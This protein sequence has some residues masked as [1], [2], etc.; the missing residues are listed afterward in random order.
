MLNIISIDFLGVSVTRKIRWAQSR[1]LG[2]LSAD[3]GKAAAL[4]R[5]SS[6][7]TV[8]FDAFNGHGQELNERNTAF[9]CQ[10]THDM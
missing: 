5:E 10:S 7:H 1:W 3:L 8:A 4:R 2:F 9:F 6:H